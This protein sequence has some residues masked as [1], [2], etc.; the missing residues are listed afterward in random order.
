[1]ERK[2]RMIWKLFLDI[3][4]D[5][6]IGYFCKPQLF[7]YMKVWS[8]F[9]GT[10]FTL[11]KIWKGLQQFCPT[12]KLWRCR[13]LSKRGKSGWDDSQRWQAPPWSPP[14]VPLFQKSPLLLYQTPVLWQVFHRPIWSSCKCSP[15]A[16]VKSREGCDVNSKFRQE[17]HFE[18]QVGHKGEIDTIPG[19]L[20]H[21]DP[22]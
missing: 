11:C 22:N 13:D 21:F 3:Y 8:D 10:C 5:G 4:D 16:R 17:Y 1:M 15:P 7:G 9:L 12:Y 20:I 6:D 14:S 18:W 2:L 19:P